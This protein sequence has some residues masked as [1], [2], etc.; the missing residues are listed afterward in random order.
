MP[1]NNKK[2]LFT[3]AHFNIRSLCTGFDMFSDVITNES[4][5]VIG[6]SETW[7]DST[8]KENVFA[9][10]DYKLIRKDRESRGGGVAFYINKSV[11]YK[12]LDIPAINDCPLEFLWISVTMSGK[13]LCLGTLYRAP[14]SNFNQSFECLENMISTFLTEYDIILFGGDL[15]V[16]FLSENLNCIHLT[17]LLNKYGLNQLISQPTRITEHSSTLI[18]LI[19]TSNKD[20]VT[21]LNVLRMDGI[22][23]HMMVDCCL[24]IKKVNLVS[25]SIPIE[26]FQNLIM[27]VF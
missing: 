5:S 23:D 17:N 22:S 20:I 8:I 26:I 4:Y 19:I 3:F 21:D 2:N 18:D 27:I 1:T 13:R 25:F 10:T 16:D 6:L 11:K 12:I 15:N 14:N 7:L 9:L 24:N